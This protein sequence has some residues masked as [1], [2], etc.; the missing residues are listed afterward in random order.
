M[1]E[2]LIIWLVIIIGWAVLKGL[3]G[4]SEEEQTEAKREFV[5]KI[6]FQA[7][8]KEEIPPKDRGLP[9]IKCIAV[10]IKGL[11]GHPTENQTKI[12]LTIHDNTDLND[13]EFG[14]P[15]LSAYSEFAEKGSRVFG[16]SVTWPS[17]PDTYLPNWYDWIYI[18]KELI[19]PPYKGKRKLKFNITACDTDT[20]VVHGGYDDLSKIKYNCSS[21]QFVN[22]RL[23]I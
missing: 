4:P 5:D 2:T 21:L 19:L 6:K 13:D 22:K 7:Q 8:I 17:S 14:P 23:A 1:G 11:F 9:Q 12:I 16:I 20:E 3:S 15:V 18:P 10:K